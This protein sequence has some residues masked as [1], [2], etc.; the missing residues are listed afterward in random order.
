MLDHSGCFPFPSRIAHSQVCCFECVVRLKGIDLEFYLSL[1]QFFTF[2]SLNRLLS[3]KVKVELK[4]LVMQQLLRDC[5]QWGI[6]LT[7]LILSVLSTYI[8][9]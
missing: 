2:V 1:D 6:I 9:A 4:Q 3:V 5:R 8:K 7:S